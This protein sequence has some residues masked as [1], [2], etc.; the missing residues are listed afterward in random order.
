MTPEYLS[1]IR[2]IYEAAL[3]KDAAERAAFLDRECQGDDAIRQQVDLLLGARQRVP[4]WL[5]EPLLAPAPIVELPANS[6][7][8]M[9]GRQLSG[10]KLIREIGRGGM[11]SVYLAERSDGAFRKQ[12][13]IK[14]V[15]PGVNGVEVLA[16]FRQEREI[17]ASLDHP[18][19][20]RLLDAATTEEGLPYFVME[21]VDG[22]PIDRWCD[23]RKLNVTQRLKLF[24]TVCDAVQYAHQR[25]IVHRDLKPGN[26]LVTADGQVKLLDFG[27]AKLLRQ[28][29]TGDET[30]RTL[31]LLMTPE[32]ASP[33]Q[34]NGD[35]ITTLTDVYSLGVVLYELLTGHRPHHLLRAAVLEMVRVLSEEEPTRPSAVV[36]TTEERLTPQA[37]SEVREGDPNRLR[38]RLEGDLDCIVL[39]ALHKEPVRRYSSVEAFG[40]DL[41][42][43]LENR[44]V[45]AREDSA[46]YRASRFVRRHP[47][48]V[49]T[50]I[51]IFFCAA[52]GFATTLWETRILIGATEPA[53]SARAMLTPLLALSVFLAIAG[54][55]VAA[56]L[57]RATLRRA[58]GALAGGAALMVVWMVKLRIDYAMGWLRSA[59]PGT[60]DPLTR[61]SLG[62]LFFGGVLSLLLWRVSRRFGWVGQVAM[63]LTTSLYFAVRD[64][65]WY[66]RFMRILIVTPGIGPVLGDA[67]IFAVALVL[68]YAVMR[69]IAGPAGKD[70]LARTRQPIS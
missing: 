4:D 58:M 70:P 57:T 61:F 63:F 43:H 55:G 46:W 48:G 6:L 11:G 59:F 16:R 3:A 26:I 38:K 17:L 33:E 66:Q 47:G 52:A 1:R 7:P 36:A 50:G 23:E 10:Y 51:L 32:Y 54:F 24:R 20:A 49:A 65:I 25:L 35:V 67:A 40:E 68:G 42:R 14:L 62:V 22:R 39:T 8:R 64:R 60:P 37:V 27:I 2:A 45:N 21:F 9:E 13:A 53:L 69:L 56:Y 18:G 28:E 12:V 30:T 29:Q 31:M 15:Q 41:G 44:P 5:N 19:I 34:V